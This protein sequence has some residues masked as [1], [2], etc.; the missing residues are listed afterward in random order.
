MTTEPKKVLLVILDGW[1]QR[2]EK[3]HNAIAAAKTPAFDLLWRTYPHA[4]LTASGEGVGLPEGQIGN[5]EIGH[6]TMGGGRIFETDLVRLNKHAK[7]GGFSKNS[8]FQKLFAHVQ[9]HDST[10]HVLGLLSPGGVHSH[11]DHLHAFLAAAKTAGVEKIAVHAFTDGRDTAP[12]SGSAYL[13]EL[14]NILEDLQIG[15][16]ATLTGRLYAM[17]RD[18]N[19]DR[20]EKAENAIFECRGQT[21]KQKKPSEVLSEL[22]KEGIIDEALEPLVFLDSTGQGWPIRNHDGVFIFNFRADRSRQLSER[23]LQRKKSQDL[24]FMTMTEYDKN[25]E[26]VTAFP[27]LRADTCLAA[28]IAKAGLRQDHIAETEKYPHVTYFF[29][30][31]REEP[32]EGERHIMIKSRGDVKT[33]DLAPRMRAKEVADKAV[34]SMADG[35]EFIVINFANADMVG[36][37]ANVPAII[38]AVEEVDRQL[39]KIWRAAKKNHYTV[40]ITSDHGNAELNLHEDGQTKHTAHTNNTVPIIAA[41]KNKEIKNGDLSDLAPTI[42]KLFGLPV[43]SGMTGKNLLS[44]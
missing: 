36:H 27:P 37:T 9:R 21:C 28:E 20:I 35:I 18:H 40:V 44:Q 32:H 6:M 11:H 16:V 39:E 13:R 30:G 33:H 41:I 19:W 22:Y 43:P 10:L 2:D 4:L 31:G 8:E 23:I 7:S 26:A 25:F 34:L 29:N 24:F 12:Q 38:E 5:S 42:L 14:E 15:F 3:K 17:D 1:G